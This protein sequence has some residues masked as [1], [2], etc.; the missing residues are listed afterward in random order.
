M[1]LKKNVLKD[2]KEFPVEIL[3]GL[4]DWYSNRDILYKEKCS[5]WLEKLEEKILPDAVVTHNDFNVLIFTQIAWGHKGQ[6]S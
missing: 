6:S 1:Y 5:V 4:C 2:L 3:L